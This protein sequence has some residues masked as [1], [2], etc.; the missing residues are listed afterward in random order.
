MNLVK[1]VGPVDLHDRDDVRPHV[2]GEVMQGFEEG[3]QIKCSLDDLAS[4]G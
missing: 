4:Q 1:P 2:I 3:V